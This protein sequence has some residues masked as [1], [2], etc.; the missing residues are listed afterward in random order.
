MFKPSKSIVGLDVGTQSIK[1]V[2]LTRT[3]KSFTVTG[4]GQLDIPNNQPDAV[5]QGIAELM[6]EGGFKTKRVVTN[7]SGQ[8]VIVRYLSM[9]PMSEEELRNAIIFEAEKYIPF[10]L[11]EC[12]M[13]CQ[14]L[15]DG[16]PQQGGG[17]QQTSNVLLVAATKNHVAEQL[18]TLQGAGV[19]PDVI[20][21]D[22]F[23]LSNA[24]SLMRTFQKDEVESE[25]VIAFVDIGASK[26]CVNIVQQGLSTFTREI[27]L[28]GRDFTQ[29]VSRRL[30]VDEVEAEALKRSPGE[31]GES[32]RDAIFPTI[33]DLGNELQLSFDYFENQHAKSVDKIYL[34]GGSSRLSFVRESFEK[35]F[36]KP[37]CVFNPFEGI[38]LS[39][40]LDQDL[41]AQS[42]PQLVIAT[43]LAARI[44]R[45]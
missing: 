32:L 30:S 42:G 43:G 19:V 44:S 35:I 28:G 21:V 40:E 45:G 37:T 31:N 22:A 23:A 14:R 1:A 9:A 10:T 25:G 33:D 27:Y 39:E 20:D 18:K 41:V 7:I 5:S 17:S 11:D 26:S 29:A 38:P 12:V 2:E 13:D 34:S 16:A 3:G 6:R 8:K 36:E 24:Y 15:G 4:F